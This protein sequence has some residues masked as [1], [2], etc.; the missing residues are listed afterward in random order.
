MKKLPLVSDRIVTHN[1]KEFL[2]R[3]LESVKKQTYKNIET[4]VVDDGSTDDF[5][6]LLG[7]ATIFVQIPKSG[8]AHARN[9]AMKESSGE[10]MFI[11]DSDDY[12]HEECIERSLDCIKDGDADWLFSDLILVDEEGKQIG[13]WK[14]KEQAFQ[15]CFNEKRIPHVSSLIRKDFI[16]DTKY[17]ER[18]MSAVDFDFALALLLKKPKLKRMETPYSYCT[19]HKNQE[20]GTIRQSDNA[21]YI[22]SKYE[23]YR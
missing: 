22:R 9:V 17:D 15:E 10:Y 21:Y 19:M 13:L 20:T 5:T 7:L 2:K 14:S 18:F 1:R 4:I 8:I 3:C 6:D 12:L 11:L 16:S 23:Q